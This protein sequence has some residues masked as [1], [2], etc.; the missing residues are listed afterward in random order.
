MK[1]SPVYTTYW[2]FAAERQAIFFERARNEPHPWTEDN[3][4]TEYKFTNC[5]RACDRVS[6]YL[7][8]K[9]IYRNDLPNS[10][11]EVFFRI[12]LFKFFN[13]I[14]TWE[15]LESHFHPI[16]F[17]DFRIELYRNALEVESQKGTRIYSAA[18]IMPPSRQ[19]SGSGS[20]IQSHLNLLVQMIDDRLPYKL[21]EAKNMQ[22][23]FEMLTDYP[24]IGNFL[25]YQFIT[26][27]NY[28][29]ITDFSEMEF[30]MPGPGARSGLRKCFSD[31]GDFDE[32]D[33]IKYMCDNQEKE[34]QRLGLDFQYLFG[35]R[36]Q[37]VD[38]QN[39]F[40][41]V[42]K[43]ARVAHPE[44]SHVSGRKRIKQRFRPNPESLLLYFPPKWGL[45]DRV[46]RFSAIS[47]LDGT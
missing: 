15:I 34:F 12:L 1:K 23:G 43:Y 32:C 8:R 37:L 38:C 14:E 4:L 36:L 21:T 42:D 24:T 7:I 19:F 6:Q 35:R 25:G 11:Q 47:Q 2:H 33:L 3:V 30:V 27:I 22:K 17:E 26:D 10:P 44:I 46:N 28:S 29:E 45:N 20:K 5:Y 13:K 31:F 9:V 41:E 18:Y 40:C 16:T 39:L